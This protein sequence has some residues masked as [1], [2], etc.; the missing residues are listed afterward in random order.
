MI[1]SAYSQSTSQSPACGGLWAIEARYPGLAFGSPW[2]T[3]KSPAFGGLNDNRILNHAK[4]VSFHRD[5][6]NGLLMKIER[7]QLRISQLESQPDLSVLEFLEREST[8]PLYG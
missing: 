6:F 2:A 5:F 1:A 7:I 8:G 4:H 3:I